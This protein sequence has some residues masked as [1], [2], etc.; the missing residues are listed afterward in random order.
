MKRILSAFALVI[1]LGG[2][3]IGCNNPAATTSPSIVPTTTTPTLPAE[4]PAESP[5]ASDLT[6]PSPSAS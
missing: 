4:S 3:I 2:A 5:A 6:S 1:A